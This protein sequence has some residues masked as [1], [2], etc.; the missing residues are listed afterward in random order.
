[1]SS[2]GELTVDLF[3]R[4]LHEY[5]SHCVKEKSSSVGFNELFNKATTRF[6]RACLTNLERTLQR[7]PAFRKARKPRW[8]GLWSWSA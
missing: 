4:V 1:V 8:A 3:Q 5:M 7:G 2:A 6:G